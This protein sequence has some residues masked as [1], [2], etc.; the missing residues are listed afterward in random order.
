MG[1][2]PQANGLFSSPQID[3]TQYSSDTEPSR[4][5]PAQGQRKERLADKGLDENVC[6]NL[7]MIR[8]ELNESWSIQRR[9]K[10]RDTL[11]AIEYSKDNQF[12]ILDPYTNSY[13]NPFASSSFVGGLAD[14]NNAANLAN[15]YQYSHNYIQFLEGVYVSVLKASIPRVEWWPDNAE[16]D[17]DNRAAQTRSRASRMIGRQNNE[18]QMLEQQLKAFFYG[19]SYFRHTRWTMDERVCEPVYEDVIDWQPQQIIPHRYACPNCGT[20]NPTDITSDMQEPQGTTCQNCGMPLGSQNFFPGVTANMPVVTGK[21]KVVK[22]Q[23]QQSIYNCLQVNAMP[24]A[25]ADSPSPL[26]NTPLIDLEAEIFSGALRGM[27]PDAWD[28]VKKGSDSTNPDGET[29]RLARLRSLSPSIQRGIIT[30]QQ[31]PTYHRTFFQPDAYDYLDKQDDAKKLHDLFPE[32]LCLATLGDDVLDARP[33]AMHKEWTWAG[34]RTDLGLYPPSRVQ[35]AMSIQDEINDNENTLQ[36]YCDRLACGPLLYNMKLIGPQLNNQHMAPGRMIGVPM[37]PNG[38]DKALSDAFYQMKTE[39]SGEVFKRTESLKMTIQLLTR[40]VPQTYGGTQKDIDTAKGQEQALRVAMGVLWGDWD[41]VRQE[42]ARA[43]MLSVD[44]FAQNAMDDVYDVVQ[45][46]DSPDFRNE[47]IR[48]ADLAGKAHAHPEADQAYPMGFEQ[49]RDLYLKMI[50]FVLSRGKENPV[51]AKVLDNY[52]NRRQMIRYVGPPDMQLPEE[53][54]RRWVQRDLVMLIEQAPV[55][56]EQPGLP[57]PMNPMVPAQPIIVTEPSVQPDPDLLKD[58]WD[59]AIEAV[60]IYLLRNGRQLQKEAPDGFKNGLAY[61]EKLRFLQQSSMAPP[62]PPGG[63]PTGPAPNPPQL[64]AGAVQPTP[65]G[66][67]PGTLATPV[68]YNEEIFMKTADRPHICPR[69][70]K[71]SGYHICPHC[72]EPSGF[73]PSGSQRSVHSCGNKHETLSTIE[74]ESK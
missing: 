28:L 61:L 74:G 69:C 13:Y 36:E 40:I 23:V 22:G 50:E 18:S 37:G 31:L 6:R 64:P 48:L 35:P 72:G 2:T 7:L 5:K 68:L 14:A 9:L 29:E 43:S 46:E 15:L 21:R 57:D 49:Q 45:D 39:I 60:V 38:L 59:Q 26:L 19:G 63:G 47:P 66:P 51:L 30:P 34:T 53:D 67:A 11:K 54:A 1:L 65:N 55:I 10:I 24:Y 73:H 8:R 62:M 3:K 25:R 33:C 16:D 71:P 41:Q 4:A 70:G 17:L 56:T 58:Y 52:Q 44:C 20:D 12:V 32:G 42:T 27:Y